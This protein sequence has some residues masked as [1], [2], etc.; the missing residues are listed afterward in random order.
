MHGQD[1]YELDEAAEQGR[2][3]REDL[4]MIEADD[5][6]ALERGSDDSIATVTPASIGMPDVGHGLPVLAGLHDPGAQLQ[7]WD[8][9]LA[10]ADAAARTR[11]DLSAAGLAAAMVPLALRLVPSLDR[12]LWPLLPTLVRGSMAL[13]VQMRRRPQDAGHRLGLIPFVL[14]RT[15]AALARDVAEGRPLPGHG[16]VLQLLESQARNTVSGEA[17]WR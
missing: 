8:M 15:V 16:Q 3:E 5:G 2:A 6:S 10:L 7:D 17:R 14:R 4:E 9:M 12:A 1:G 13:A 11:T